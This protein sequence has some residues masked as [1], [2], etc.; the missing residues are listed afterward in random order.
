MTSLISFEADDCA[1]TGPIPTEIGRLV[2][3]RTFIALYLPLAV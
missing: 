1:L 2:N 3:L